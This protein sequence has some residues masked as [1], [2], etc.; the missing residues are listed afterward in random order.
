MIRYTELSMN[1]GDGVN[2]AALLPVNHSYVSSCA[3]S[4]AEEPK[5]PVFQS[6][7][8]F[9]GVS[10]EKR[11]NGKM[12]KRKSRFVNVVTKVERS[13]SSELRKVLFGSRFRFRLW[14]KI[15]TCAVAVLLFFLLA[16]HLFFQSPFC[17]AGSPDCAFGHVVV[18][19]VT[20]TYK[21]P[22]QA[23]DLTRLSQ[24]LMLAKAKI[25]WVIVE[26]AYAP[27]KLVGDILRRSG[28]DGVQLLGKTPVQHKQLSAG[29]GVA[30]RR[31]ALAWLRA[32]ATAPAV[33]YF[34]DD[35]NSYDHRV[36]AQITQVRKVGVFPVGLVGGFGISSPV[37]SRDGRVTGFH[38][39]YDRRFAVDMAGFAV[40]L[41]LV[42]SAEQ[43]QMPY[44]LGRLETAFLE[45]L[46]VAL[47]DLEPLANNCT[48]VLVWH[49][50]DQ[51]ARFIT[52]S[53]ITH[54][55]YVNTN[56]PVLYKNILEE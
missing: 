1:E 26:D 25:F 27:S 28:L 5:S 30:P 13:I 46:G 17:L 54:K 7:A 11:G 53:S 42:L 44:K 48:E 37:V 39:A 4:C 29:K 9:L 45:S 31:R 32:N 12:K 10:E 36:F 34:A 15:G 35:D 24:A 55:K 18:Y 14:L 22:T 8:N 41:Q 19:V 38:D 47:K 40:N 51:R 33:L 16:Q 56:I 21:R 2:T 3:K 49:T 6:E 23:P 43:P 20:P 50:K 52:K